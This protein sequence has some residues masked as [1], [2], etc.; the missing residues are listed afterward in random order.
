M[1]IPEPHFELAC[2]YDDGTS[3]AIIVPV[4]KLPWD[5]KMGRRGFLG[6]GLTTVAVLGAACATVPKQTESRHRRTLR[7]DVAKPDCS[8]APRQREHGAS[9]PDCGDVRAHADDICALAISPDSK[10]LASGDWGGMIKLWSLPEGA[11]IKTLQG[12]TKKVEAL[13]ISPDGKTLASGDVGGTIKLWSLPEGTLVNTLEGDVATVNALAISPD[14]K[15]L[16]SGD[17]GGMIKLWS[18][19]EGALVKIL[20]GDTQ[21]TVDT[22]AISPDGKNLVTASTL[23]QGSSYRPSLAISPDGKTLA[24]GGSWDETIE[25]W[26]LPE[27]ALIKTLQGPTESVEAVGTIIKVIELWRLPEGALVKTLEGHKDTVSSLVISPDGR[28]LASGSYDGTIKLWRLPQGCLNETLQGH[29]E[30]VRA[31]AISANGKTLVSGDV[32]TQIMLWSLPQGEFKS[33]L[34]DL[35][36]TPSNVKGMTYQWRNEYGQLITYTLPCG[37]PIPAGAVCTCNCVPGTYTPPVTNDTP[38]GGGSYRI[39]TCVPVCI[40]VPVCQ[41]HKV[42]D[43]NSVVR[44]MAEEILMLMGSREFEYM[45]WAADNAEPA[46]KARIHQIVDA[47]RAGAKPNP[48]RWPSVD[49]CVARLHD[50]D[51]VVALMAAQ[52]LTQLQRR[53]GSRFAAWIE[54]RIAELQSDAVRRPWYLRYAANARRVQRSTKTAGIF[55]SQK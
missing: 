54:E 6:A 41:A 8:N 21:K 45:R 16:A 9:K 29:T 13:A 49:V 50:A 44:T 5:T 24:S 47:I 43:D 22:L 32:K 1:K 36:A 25:L 37:S 42:L 26:S 3:E 11:L 38:R 7:T 35:K 14:G 31:L 34:I 55:G 2:V 4:T 20:K 30:G 28:I 15:T 51:E 52:L 46:L 19:P 18:L 10:T 39:C 27:G 23:S 33:C 53:T 48:A 40:C 17:W 12:N